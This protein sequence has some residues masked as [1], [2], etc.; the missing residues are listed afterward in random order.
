MPALHLLQRLHL[1]SNHRDILLEHGLRTPTGHI[2][3]PLSLSQNGNRVAMHG[4]LLNRESQLGLYPRS[5]DASSKALWR[6]RRE[7]WEYSFFKT[8]YCF[9]GVGGTASSVVHHCSFYDGA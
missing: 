3:R 2:A 7:K 9:K 1:R 5:D 6:E 8:I 4:H